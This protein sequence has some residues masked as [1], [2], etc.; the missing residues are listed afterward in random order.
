MEITRTE[1]CWRRNADKGR[2]VEM[3]QALQTHAIV[4][5]IRQSEIKT[6]IN[7]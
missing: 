6:V 1:T 7:M 5:N 4:K 2:E 3:N